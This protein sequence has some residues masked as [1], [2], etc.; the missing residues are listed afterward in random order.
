[1]K[2]F[3][4]KQ[5]VLILS[6]AV[7]LELARYL[8]FGSTYYLFL[9]WNLFLAVL[10]FL[11]SRTPYIFNEKQ[12]L[13][14]SAFIIISLFWLLLIPNAPYIVTDLIHLSHRHGAPLI[15]DAFL[16]FTFAWAGL[17]LFFYSLRDIE[18]IITSKYGHNIAMIKIP[19]IILLSSVGVYMGRYLRFNSW[20]VFVD[21]SL[22]GDTIDKLSQSTSQKEA[23]IFI[24]LSFVFLCFFYKAFKSKEN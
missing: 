7:L 6:L 4:P 24:C 17:L 21:H 9:L 13:K 12:K 16:I 11:I 14:N 8:V 3:F 23:M 18:R 5:I 15:Y 10:P 19:S 1:M 20:D 22:I 2:N